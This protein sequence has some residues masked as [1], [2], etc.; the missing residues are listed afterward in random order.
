MAT[1]LI[2]DQSGEPLLM[3]GTRVRLRPVNQLVDL[4]S[5]LGT[6]VR[7]DEWDDYYIV[8]LDES[9]MYHDP[10]GTTRDVPEIAQIVDNLEVL[11]GPTE[12]AYG[13][14]NARRLVRPCL[15]GEVDVSVRE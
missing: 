1:S 8:L 2:R 10:D 5:N 14:G 12:L 11:G 4:R 13:V 3:P 6:V 15:R 9:A 7:P